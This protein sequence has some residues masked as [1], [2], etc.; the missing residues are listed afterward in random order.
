MSP[1][2][3]KIGMK[4]RSGQ[5]VS[6]HVRAQAEADWGS[7]LAN[8]SVVVTVMPHFLTNLVFSHQIIRA[9][10]I[11]SQCQ[12]HAMPQPTMK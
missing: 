2:V 1:D 5:L 8:V 6:S 12:K 4:G 3:V 7:M 11:A 10:K 9:T